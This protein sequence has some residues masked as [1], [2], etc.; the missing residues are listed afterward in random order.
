LKNILRVLGDPTATKGR[1][2]V[3]GGIFSLIRAY[4]KPWRP[5][6]ER[7]VDMVND[8]A[9]SLGPDCP[10]PVIVQLPWRDESYG[11]FREQREQVHNKCNV[12]NVKF[13]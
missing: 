2:Y 12:K 9:S 8:F 3:L 13:S 7:Y 6:V 10:A 5:L 1:A 11:I 4:K